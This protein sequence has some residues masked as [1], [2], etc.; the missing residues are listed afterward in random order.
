MPYFV[1]FDDRR[2]PPHLYYNMF[3]FI[4]YSLQTESVGGYNTMYYLES[5]RVVVA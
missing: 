3:T 2:L 5:V 1:G 4:G